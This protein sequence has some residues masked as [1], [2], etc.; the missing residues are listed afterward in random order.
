MGACERNIDSDSESGGSSSSN[1][2]DSDYSEY[3]EIE[4][5]YQ[6]DASDV[7]TIVFNDNTAEITGDGATFEDGILTVSSQGNY[8]FQGT[9]TDGEILVSADNE[10]VVKLILDNVSVTCSDNPGI[11]IQ[12][13]LRTIVI[14]NDNTTNSISDGNTF[15]DEDANAAL[16]SK[17]DLRLSGNGTLNIS[18]NY[19]DGIT[20]KDGLVINSGNYNITANDDGIRG[21]DYLI[22]NDGTFVIDSDG[23]AVKSD[24][25]NSAC[26]YINIVY[27]DFTID[28]YSD[29]L[30]AY[31][32]ITIT[33]GTFNITC[34]G[35]TSSAKGIKAGTL[36]YIQN[37]EF[38]INSVDDAV[39]SDLDIMI[40][41]GKLTLSTNDDGIHAENE[42]EI[43][44]GTIEI[45]TSYE[46]L[47]ART[48]TINGGHIDLTASDDG[49]NAAGGNSNYLYINGGT[50]FVYAYGDGL[51]MNGSGEMTAGTVLV[52]GPTN[53]GNG[54]LDYD[55]SFKVNGGLL[56]A[57]GSSGMAEAPS[58]SSSQYAAL[59]N[60]TSSYSANTLFHLEDNSGNTIATFKPAHQ[61]QSVAI[62]SPDLSSGKTYSIYTGGSST[63]TES[64]GLYTNGEYTPGT[65]YQSFTISSTITS[66]G[67]QSGGGPGGR[68]SVSSEEL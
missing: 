27:A 2:D 25:E 24:N 52:H 63:G 22:I 1:D 21:K 12:K 34:N 39:H 55:G 4:T 65:E 59:I 20:S 51:D 16:F 8:L 40:N 29:G 33:D 42:L 7:T 14:L 3:Y 18:A 53:S 48:I 49:I 60:F 36:V 15:T 13:S 61:Y 41:D 32:K 62:S 66:I 31:N 68:R 11:Y 67:S 9:L 5:D 57:A 28:T 35:S 10:S 43:N 19:K 26:G 44:N 38:T 47:E 46:G 58:T 37:G 17:S 6:W 23:D 54:A 45:L 50:V 64:G 30:Y 56:I